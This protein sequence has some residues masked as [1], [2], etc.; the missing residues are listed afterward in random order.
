MKRKTCWTRLTILFLCDI[1]FIKGIFRIWTWFTID[2]PTYRD[3]VNFSTYAFPEIN[4]N[5]SSLFG[6]FESLHSR[7][8]VNGGR[9]D[10]YISLIFRFSDD[11]KFFHNKTFLWCKKLIII[12][13]T[14]SFKTDFCLLLRKNTHIVILDF[15]LNIL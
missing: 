2:K 8:C 15:S 11:L 5:L 12:L 14:I 7:I 1:R 4:V 6:N 13:K 3:Q 9:L 10:P